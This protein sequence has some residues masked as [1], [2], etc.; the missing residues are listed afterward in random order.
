MPLYYSIGIGVVKSCYA[1]LQFQGGPVAVLPTQRTRVAGKPMPP[2][3]QWQLPFPPTGG[4]LMSTCRHAFPPSSGFG[5]GRRC[6]NRYR[7]KMPQAGGFWPCRILTLAEKGFDVNDLHHTLKNRT[8][9]IM[10]AATDGFGLRGLFKKTG[11][12]FCRLI[13]IR[14]EN[15]HPPGFQRITGNPGASDE[16]RCRIYARGAAG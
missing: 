15:P 3:I 9:P 1:W 2:E 16:P 11:D 4:I 10:R 13:P 14:L 8:G 12:R 6:G 5:S 7:K